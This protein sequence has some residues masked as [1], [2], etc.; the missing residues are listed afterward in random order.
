M[1]NHE[2]KEPEQ[3]DEPGGT[4]R[5][6]EHVCSESELEGVQGGGQVRQKGAAP[7]ISPGTSIDV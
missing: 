3:F 2:R 4:E 1:K 7:G 5:E 6:P